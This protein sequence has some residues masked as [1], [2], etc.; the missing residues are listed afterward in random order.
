[1]SF[2]FSV[3]VVFSYSTNA[4]IDSLC[5]TLRWVCMKECV[6]KVSRISA[7][8]SRIRLQTRHSLPRFSQRFISPCARPPPR[9]DEASYA[10]MDQISIN[11]YCKVKM[12]VCARVCL[13]VACVTHVRCC[14]MSTSCIAWLFWSVRRLS[15][16]RVGRNETRS[17]L[18]L[19][20]KPSH[21]KLTK[22][23]YING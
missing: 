6:R 8:G 22:I 9:R 15:Y 20:S 3:S 10:P 23:N 1:M 19:E 7:F 14:N 17:P 5:A 11:H 21:G 16:H 18:Y 4:W 2:W 12:V 13:C